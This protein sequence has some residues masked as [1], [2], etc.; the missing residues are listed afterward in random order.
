[1]NNG[2]ALRT[3]ISDV[4]LIT[5]A[6][7]FGYVAAFNYHREYVVVF[8]IPPELIAFDTSSFLVAANNIWTFTFAIGFIAWAM[9]VIGGRPKTAFQTK[10]RRFVLPLVVTAIIL[11]LY[12]RG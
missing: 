4:L 6:S 1:M 11:N 12:Q 3:T 10:Q 7:L 8:G 9:Y 2:P 5:F